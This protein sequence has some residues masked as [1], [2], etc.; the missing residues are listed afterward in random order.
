LERV[1][2]LSDTAISRPGHWAGEL[3]QY[4]DRGRHSIGRVS[5]GPDARNPHFAMTP[6]GPVDQQHGL[7]GCVIEVVDNLLD[8]DMALDRPPPEPEDPG[9]SVRGDEPLLGTGVG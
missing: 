3:A 4:I 9:S 6:A 1:A 5:T 8:E 7:V 2:D